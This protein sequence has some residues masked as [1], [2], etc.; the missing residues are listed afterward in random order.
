RGAGL[1]AVHAPD[2]RDDPGE[3]H[4]PAPQMPERHTAGRGLADSADQR[5]A[6][7]CR[8]GSGVRGIV[9]ES[10]GTEGRGAV[11]GC[12]AAAGCRRAGGTAQVSGYMPQGRHPG[13]P[14]GP[15]VPAVAYAAP[16][17]TAAGTGGRG[18]RSVAGGC[19]GGGER[20][21]L[22]AAVNYITASSSRST[23]A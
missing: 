21:A 6:V 1:P 22:I 10:G 23:A 13:D 17:G 20:L 4:H 3:R 19:T 8:G 16:G 14:V 5:A 2:R 11:S 9:A 15:A 18:V 12:R 7:F